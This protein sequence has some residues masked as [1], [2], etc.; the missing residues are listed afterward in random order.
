MARRIT[1]YTSNTKRRN[2]N[3]VMPRD[4]SIGHST[5][6]HTPSYAFFKQYGRYF[7]LFDLIESGRLHIDTRRGIV[8]RRRSRRLPWQVARIDTDKQR[9]YQYIRLY[10]TVTIYDKRGR[11]VKRYYS[12]A[13]CLQ[14]VVWLV[15]N[16]QRDIPVGHQVD[17]KN[18]RVQDNRETNLQLL[19][20]AA[21]QARRYN[22]WVKDN[23]AAAN[24]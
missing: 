17:H 11:K 14:I 15:A 6:Y 12:Q 8:Y 13:I 10:R 5:Y 19:T 22:K 1:K 2:R 7:L 24:F 20:D 16:N 21:N 9:G 23:P 4:N 18:F 3:G